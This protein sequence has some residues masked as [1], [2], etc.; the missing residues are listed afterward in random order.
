M[1]VHLREA[2]LGHFP[3]VGVVAKVHQAVHLGEKARRFGHIAEGVK[4][5]GEIRLDRK[6]ITEVDGYFD[7]HVCLQKIVVGTI[8]K[9]AGA[10]A[11]CAKTR[12]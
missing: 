2:D 10:H 7:S 6:F 3:T 1:Q 11:P 5:R 8:R 12:L 4:Y 9:E